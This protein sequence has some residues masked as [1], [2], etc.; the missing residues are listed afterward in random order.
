[1]KSP[2]RTRASSS[3][4][5]GRLSARILYCLTL[6]ISLAAQAF[7]Q[8]PGSKDLDWHTREQI[9]L[10]NEEKLSRTPAQRKVDS[11]LLYSARQRR[12][13]TVGFGLNALKPALRLE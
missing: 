1:M 12:Q 2:K 8:L 5:H 10:L 11:Q 13:G 4:R 7:D 3:V 9:R 6:T